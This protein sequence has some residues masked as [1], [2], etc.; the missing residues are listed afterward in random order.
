LTLTQREAMDR[1]EWLAERVR[2]RRRVTEDSGR[3]PDETVADFVQSDLLRMNQAS[4][5]GGHELGCAAVVELVSKVAEGD[6]SSGWV[7][8]LLASHFW[9]ASVFGYE[10][11]TE[12]WG[13]DPTTMMSSSFAARESTVVEEPKGLRVSGRWPY[14]SGS[15]H[16][17]WAMLGLV[18]PPPDAETPPVAKWGILPRS[19]Y[20]VD[21]D[22]DTCAL[23]GT[24][25]NTLVVEDAFIPEHRLVDPTLILAGMGPGREVNPGSVFA[26][27]FASALGWYLGSTALGCATQVVGDFASNSVK[28]VS[29]FTGQP[30]LGE[31][32]T[33]HIGTASANV[34]AARAVMRHRAAWIDDRLRQG[35]SLT[36]E[37]SLASARDATSAVRLCVDAAD[38]CMRFSGAA[39]LARENPVQSG[40]RDVHGVAAHMGYN[41]DTVF[42]TWGRSMLGLPIP[43]GFF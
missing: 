11:Q 40:W 35:M 7:F 26:L 2:S 39:G 16:C 36:R 31:A 25:S 19:D 32:L 34:E 38:R 9:L 20:S 30:V 27:G 23:R 10:L 22:W 12:M 28:K 29:A 42:G 13:T 8:G 21:N 6:G 37:E 33:I 15:P 5:W 3:L 14:S 1:A 17:T 41:T 43:P 24:A 4:R 18:I